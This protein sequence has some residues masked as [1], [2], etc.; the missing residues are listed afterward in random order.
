MLTVDA[1]TDP[2]TG[3][4]EG[5]KLSK[6]S[7]HFPGLNISGPM[8]FSTPMPQGT[9]ATW[10]LSLQLAGLKKLTGTGVITTPSR[11]LGLDL[12][13]TF[14][15]SIFKIK[16]KGA[17]DVPNAL[18]GAGSSAT[19]QLTPTFDTILFKGKVLGQKLYFSYPED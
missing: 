8:E 12:S 3:L 5:T 7:S 11:A 19:I 2:S 1:E 10:N 6:F 17:N 13:G 9:N 4:L 15:N 16:A 18:N 14:K